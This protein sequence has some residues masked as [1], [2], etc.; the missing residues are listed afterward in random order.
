MPRTREDIE[1]DI[2]KEQAL[3]LAAGTR[4]D[5]LRKE[6]RELDTPVVTGEVEAA[7]LKAEVDK[8]IAEYAK[9]VA[10]EEP[11]L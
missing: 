10:V 7:A 2:A 4:M 9:P 8:A 11:I 6:L 5:A 1:A 3:W